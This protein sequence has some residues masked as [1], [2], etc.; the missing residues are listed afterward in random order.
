M[1]DMMLRPPE[2]G[3]DLFSK[4]INIWL[5]GHSPAQAHRNRVSHLKKGWWMKPCGL[6]L[7][8]TP[9]GIDSGCGPAGEIQDF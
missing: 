4:L 6:N 8:I 7:P 1:V 2:E 5:L 3:D 9:A